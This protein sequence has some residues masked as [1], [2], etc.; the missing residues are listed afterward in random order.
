VVSNRFGDRRSIGKKSIFESTLALSIAASQLRS[1]F[2][3]ALSRNI[4][5]SPRTRG[6]PS[7]RCESASWESI[8][9]INQTNSYFE[10]VVFGRNPQTV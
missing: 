3:S 1:R 4:H 7:S 9:F 10:F 5:T 6:L 8:S 2:E